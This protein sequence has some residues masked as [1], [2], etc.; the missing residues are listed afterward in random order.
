MDIVYVHSRKMTIYF[1]RILG[2]TN[3]LVLSFVK[4]FENLLEVFVV[5]VRTEL[6]ERVL[7][8]VLTLHWTLLKHSVNRFSSD[9]ITCCF[10]R[11]YHRLPLQRGSRHFLG[12][13]FNFRSSEEI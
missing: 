12:S 10:K 4:L 3:L 7:H 9:L 11:A 2:R 5:N 8:L 6:I 13:L 1:V